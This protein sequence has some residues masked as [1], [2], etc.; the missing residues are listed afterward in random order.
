MKR[1]RDPIVGT[2]IVR[3]FRSA[4]IR[5]PDLRILAID[6][7]SYSSRLGTIAAI[8]YKVNVSVAAAAMGPIKWRIECVAVLDIFRHAP[9]SRGA[10][11]YTALCEE[12]VGAGFVR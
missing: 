11:D 3:C 12:L 8:N 2:V 5:V 1:D 7:K 4:C 6:A 10:E 9:D